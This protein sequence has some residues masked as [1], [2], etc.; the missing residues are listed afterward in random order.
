MGRINVTSPIF[1]DS[2]V[3]Q[4]LHQAPFEGALVASSRALCARPARGVTARA[5]RERERERE[6]ER[7]RA[8]EERARQRQSKANAQYDATIER[9]NQPSSGILAEG[10][11]ALPVTLSG[12]ALFAS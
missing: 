6:R 10:A 11:I 7:D 3:Q 1:V 4:L 8:G 9:Y 12:G 5:D 2:D